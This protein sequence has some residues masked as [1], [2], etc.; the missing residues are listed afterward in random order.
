[1]K[2]KRMLQC[3]LKYWC[4]LP[5]ERGGECHLPANEGSSYTMSSIKR[6]STGSLLYTRTFILS[7]ENDYNLNRKATNH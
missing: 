1:M 4:L 7:E 5:K 3:L 6:K 2:H